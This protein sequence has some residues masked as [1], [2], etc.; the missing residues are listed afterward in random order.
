MFRL[1]WAAS[2]RIHNVLRWAPTNMLVDRI[3]TRRGLKWGIPAMLLVVPLVL[4]AAAC[5]AGVHDGGPGWFNL[6]VILFIWDALKF[7]VMGPAS[8][9]LLAR[10]RAREARERR[11][12]MR[13]RHLVD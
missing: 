13:A 9:F 11:C 7:L 5:V 8:L 6:L 12:G 3:R 4:A 2:I 1:I 10:V